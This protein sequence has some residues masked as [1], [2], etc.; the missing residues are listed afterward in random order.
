[1]SNFTD[2]FGNQFSASDQLADAR[3]ELNDLTDGVDGTQMHRNAVIG[4]RL[5]VHRHGI[6]GEDQGRGYTVAIRV[7]GQYT[8][9]GIRKMMPRAEADRLVSEISKLLPDDPIGIPT[10]RGRPEGTTKPE[11]MRTVV[12]VRL[13]DAEREDIERCMA[14][15]SESGSE[16]IRGAISMRCKKTR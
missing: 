2:T 9:Y 4:K 8:D 15:T 16:F 6:S 5:T 11:S 14:I 13:S 1:M 12:S 3:R 10:H 7:E